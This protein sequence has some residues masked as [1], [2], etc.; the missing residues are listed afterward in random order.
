M[1]WY[2]ITAFLMV[3]FLIAIPSLAGIG[4]GTYLFFVET[5]KEIKRK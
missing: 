3:T 4:Y 5:I 2:D 1:K